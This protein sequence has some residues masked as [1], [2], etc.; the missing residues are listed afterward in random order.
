MAAAE[1][2]QV[3]R[4]LSARELV[5]GQILEAALSQVGPECMVLLLVRSVVRK[6]SRTV[7]SNVSGI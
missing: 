3:S 4:S 2:R 7:E 5:F 6:H 1:T